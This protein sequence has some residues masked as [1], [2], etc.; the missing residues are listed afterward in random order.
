[1]A[2]PAGHSASEQ[3]RREQ[4][5]V[6]EALDSVAEFYQATEDEDN[7]IAQ[8]ADAAR[9]SAV[10]LCHADETPRAVR[11]GSDLSEEE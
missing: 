1:M 8:M 6:G 9:K 5:T 7:P 11:L 2:E 10:G 3:V 4:R